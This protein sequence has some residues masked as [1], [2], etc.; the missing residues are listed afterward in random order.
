M[1]Q[2]RDDLHRRITERHNQWHRDS[3]DLYQMAGM[4]AHHLAQDVFTILMVEIVGYCHQFNLEP[5]EISDAINVA[6]RGFDFVVIDL[7]PSY[8]ALNQAVFEL[9]DRILVPVTPDVPAL[10]ARSAA[11]GHRRSDST[12]MTNP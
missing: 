9:A 5:E 11:R 1:S 8:S 7:H 3:V 6:R 2:L 4:R 12:N 10:R